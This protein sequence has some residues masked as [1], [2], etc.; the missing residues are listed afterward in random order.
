MACTTI[1]VG[2]NASFDG[3]TLVAR[4]EDSPSGQ[5]TPKAFVVVQPEDQP[6]H[7][8]SVLSD[9]EIDLPDNPIRY[10]A[11][12]DAGNPGPEGFWAAS[13]INEKNV[14]MSA[15]ETITTNS[16]VLGADPLV[17]AGIGEE[18]MVT[19]VLPYISS[20][21]EG[22]LRLGQILEEYGTYESNGIAFSD[23]EEIWWLE[24]IGGHH[25]IARRVPDDVYV[26]NPNQLGLDHFEFDN[27]D[28]YLYSSDLRDWIRQHHLDLNASNEHFNPRYAF[29][30]QKDK[31]KHYNT[32]RAWFIQKFLNPEVQ[33]D[34]E[35]FALPWCR[36]PYRK[37]T[38]DDIRYLLTG[39]YQDTPYDPYTR[40]NTKISGYRPIG[41][42]RTNQ[43]HILQV[44]PNKPHDTTGIQWLSYGSMPYTTM[45]P[46]FTQVN[47]TPAYLRDTPKTPSTDS[48]Y[49]TSRIIAAL[50][51]RN[52]H[53]MMSLVDDYA[54][55][56]IAKGYAV[57]N[58]VDKA[59]A[60][61]TYYNLEN[62][63]QEVSDYLQKQTEDL[64][65]KVLYDASNHMTNAFSMSD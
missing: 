47:D 34:P 53:E 28:H 52:H 57:I 61:G 45:V 62:S 58:A 35:S 37:V 33:Q 17:K 56:T 23:T 41:V 21:R 55:D 18:D 27:P 44:R 46:F 16:R 19:L 36:K 49:W 10:T 25:W 9:F 1:L 2:K 65:D 13:G 6:R 48:Y 38:I 29:G 8:K 64:L 3:S 63:N 60:E 7:Y 26:T 51:D 31:D 32:P 30:S 5:Y 40:E 50:A 42:N 39:Y 12:P 24:T 4:T 22:V 43:T 14:A 15:T 54:E 11:V 59:Q 20:A